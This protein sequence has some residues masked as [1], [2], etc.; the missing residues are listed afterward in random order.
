MKATDIF[1]GKYLASTDLG[2]E[3]YKLVIA[4]TELVEFENEGKKQKKIHIIFQNAKKGLLANKTNS[5]ILAE[6][7]GDETDGWIGKEVIL[8]VDMVGFQGKAVKSIRVKV[9]RAAKP[10]AA[11][12]DDMND[13]VPF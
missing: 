6:A 4:G 7:Y 1:S 10:K 3:E 12:K 13:E 11:S 8:Y 5:M 9:P 2:D